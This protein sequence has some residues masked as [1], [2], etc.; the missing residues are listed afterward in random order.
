M[1]WWDIGEAT[2]EGIF[3]ISLHDLYLDLGL[4]HC[5]KVVIGG[6]EHGEVSVMLVGEDIEPQRGSFAEKGN[7]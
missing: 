6:S 4:S 3:K 7:G 5:I 2:P 1:R